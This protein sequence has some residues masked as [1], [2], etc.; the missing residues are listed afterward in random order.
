VSMRLL[1][2][3]SCSNAAGSWQL[4]M[5]IRNLGYGYSFY[6]IKKYTFKSIY[7]DFLILLKSCLY[8]WIRIMETASSSKIQC[9]G[10]WN[11]FECDVCV[12]V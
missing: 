10:G 7:I 8:N 9:C 12:D 2:F 11:I 6:L 1:C 3:C 4:M 5:D